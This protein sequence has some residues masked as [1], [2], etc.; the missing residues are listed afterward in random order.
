MKIGILIE[1]F[2]DL[3]NW[4]LRIVDEIIS[5]PET[6]LIVLIHEDGKKNKNSLKDKF[7]HF[8]RA[9]NKVAQILFALQNS[10]ENL[11]YRQPFTFSKR[12]IADTLKSIDVFR[13]RQKGNEFVGICND[14]DEKEIKDLGLDLILKLKYDVVEEKILDASKNGVWSFQFGENYSSCTKYVGFYEVLLGRPD[15]KVTLLQLLSK[16]TQGS[17]IDTAFFNRHWS[18]A[19]TKRTTLEASVNL[20]FKN[21]RK[22]RGLGHLPSHSMSDS[23]AHL[24]SPSLKETLQYIM[25]FYLRVWSKIIRYIDSLVLGAR[26]GCWT[27]FIGEGDFMTADLSA[28]KPIKLPKREFWADPFIFEY[29]EEK[30]VFFENYGYNTKRGKISCGKIENSELVDIQDVLDLKYHLSFPFIFEEDGMLYLMPE[31]KENN[32]LELYRCI[33]FPGKW[34][35]HATAFEGEKVVDAFFHNDDSGQKWMF[36]NKQAAPF[37]PADSELYIYKVGSLQLNNL[38]PH[39]LNPVIINSRKA[40]N[41]GAI[42]KFKN[43]TYRPSQ[44]NTDGVYGRALNVNKIEKLTLEEYVEKDIVTVYPDFHKGLMAMHHLHQSGSLFVID[45]A[46]RKK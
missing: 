20:F 46:Y 14:E 21:I 19:K 23:S 33:D 37:A 41:G 34:E 31:T 2:E 38:E 9:K 5:N 24:R 16:T 25:S 29:K 11:I 40:R 42:F 4:E 35:L 30:F 13:F 44:A 10:I 8:L 27:L 17:I 12:K 6:E 39:K 28:L 32:R 45:A 18:F 43:E 1:R 36:V 15:V 26:Y 7:S 22:L 3:V